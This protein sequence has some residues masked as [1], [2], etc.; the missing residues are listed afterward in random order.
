MGGGFFIDRSLG[1]KIIAAALRQADVEVHVHDDYFPSDARDENWL[2]EVGRKGWIVL[3]KDQRIRYR[4]TEL[5]ALIKAQVRTFVLTGR[6]LQGTEMARIFVKAL[7]AIKRFTTKYPPP[8]IAKVTR[9][10]S[11]S[12]VFSGT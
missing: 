2:Q 3:T 1:K 5:T 9:G 7:P 10:G 6:D 4:E 8:F 11:V 12:M